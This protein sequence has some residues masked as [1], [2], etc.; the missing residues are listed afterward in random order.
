MIEQGERE[1]EKEECLLPLPPSF[2][3]S[4]F[5]DFGKGEKK[6]FFFLGTCGVW[7]EQASLLSLTSSPITPKEE[8]EIPKEMC[9]IRGAAVAAAAAAA[10]S[11]LN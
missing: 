2:S 4:R 3:I 1:R 9:F 11:W 10:A 5:N 7:M 8:G 6:F